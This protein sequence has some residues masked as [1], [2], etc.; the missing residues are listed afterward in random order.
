MTR[1][2]V[3]KSRRPEAERAAENYLFHVCGCDP[4]Q[5]V[6]AVRTKWQ[7]EDLWACDVIGRDIDGRCY[8][9]QATAGQTEAVRTRRRK[10]ERISWN[11][12]DTV[13]V[14]Q[15]VESPDPAN[16]RRKQWWFRVHRYDHKMEIWSVDPDAAPVPTEWFKKLNT[17]G[18]TQ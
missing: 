9:A 12:Y 11:L 18:G 15:L 17:E 16:H 13:M 14:L 10:I 6:R 2:K 3:A 5:I 7:R 8:Y 4:A 1:A